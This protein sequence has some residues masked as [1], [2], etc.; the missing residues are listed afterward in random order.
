MREWV[1]QKESVAAPLSAEC[2]VV[3]FNLHELLCL[4][5]PLPSDD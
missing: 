4:Q 1:T 3:R 2:S 5:E